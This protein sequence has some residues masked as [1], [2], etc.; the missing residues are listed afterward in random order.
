MAAKK[1]MTD[2]ERQGAS[3]FFQMREMVKKQNREKRLEAVQQVMAVKDLP[4]EDLLISFLAEND[5]KVRELI[6]RD[7]S[8]RPQVDEQKLCRL[9]A[10]SPWF[11]K[12]AFVEIL[13][14]RHSELLLEKLDDLV[15]DPNAE[16][17]LKVVGALARFNR[18]RVETYLVQL[19]HDA[20]AQVRREAQQTLARV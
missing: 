8:Q 1:A 6:I 20:H 16:V 10:R 12:S 9:L 18:E 17:R 14:N 2:T 19:T 11:I 4:V 5:L 7:L 13:G 15:R 3:D